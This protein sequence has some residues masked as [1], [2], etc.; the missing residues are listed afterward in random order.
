[1][2]LPANVKAGMVFEVEV[3][4]GFP[5]AGKKTKFTLPADAESDGTVYVP[6][7]KEEDK[8]ETLKQQL[9]G[10]FGLF[11]NENTSKIGR[12]SCVLII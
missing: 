10:E 5:Q 3:P 8:L 12:A 9:E 7:P 6:F 4:P 11:A 2:R 1:M